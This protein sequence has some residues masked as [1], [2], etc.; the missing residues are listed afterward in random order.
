MSQPPEKEQNRVQLSIRIPEAMNRAFQAKVKLAGSDNTQ[1][2]GR[3][4]QAYVDDEPAAMAI[5]EGRSPEKVL[6]V[7]G[8]FVKCPKHLI[9]AI[10]RIINA[11]MEPGA[12]QALEAERQAKALPGPQAVPRKKGG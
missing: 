3:L 1:I 6:Q 12:L 9:P 5:A 7:E 10:H 4:I 2:V 8:E 11:L